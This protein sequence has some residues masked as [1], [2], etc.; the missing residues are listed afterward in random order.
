LDTVRR[1]D[2]N[3]TKQALQW[4]LQF[5]RGRGRPKNIVESK[6]VERNVM[7]TTSFKRKWKKTKAAAQDRDGWTEV[8]WGL[9]STGSDKL[10]KVQTPLVPRSVVDLF[11]MLCNKSAASCT[12]S[13]QKSKA[14]K[15]STTCR[16]VVQLVVRLV[17][18][19][20]VE[21]VELRLAS[22][23]IYVFCEFTTAVGMSAALHEVKATGRNIN[24][25]R[26]TGL[27]KSERTNS[28]CDRETVAC[29]GRQFNRTAS[30]DVP[31][32]LNFTHR[33]T[34]FVAEPADPRRPFL[35]FA[36]HQI[37]DGFGGP[38]SQKILG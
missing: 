38:D 37:R 21:V 20:Q 3:I 18:Q 11:N 30:R 26:R 5:H 34:A 15:K 17:V 8:I 24:C 2:D 16:N 35:R 31:A 14:Y 22:S 19:Q 9:R 23:H 32:E 29:G 12:I 28:E 10:S 4:T 25:P 33:A 6:H 1:K 27:W 7:W 13:L 36:G